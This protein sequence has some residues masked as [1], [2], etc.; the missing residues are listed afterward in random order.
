MAEL[1]DA[2]ARNRQPDA[3][4]VDNLGTMATIE[5][6]YRSISERRPV[7]IASICENIKAIP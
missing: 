2:I 5:A 7:D 4:G 3:S 1:M 6:A